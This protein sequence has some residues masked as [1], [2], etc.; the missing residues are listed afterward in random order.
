M[1]T[2][3]LFLILILLADLVFGLG[4]KYYR[5]FYFDMILHFLGGFFVAMFFLHYFK[6]TN[7]GKPGSPEFKKALIIISSA[8]FVGVIWEFLE[9]SATELLGDY[10][11]NNYRI[12]CCIGNLDD[13]I[14]DLLMDILGALAFV[15]ITFKSINKS[16]NKS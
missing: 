4:F 11:Y 3:I 9:Y 1:K 5:L 10:L 16:V 8:V 2:A 15:I 12:I 7:H 13:T 6:N 14:K